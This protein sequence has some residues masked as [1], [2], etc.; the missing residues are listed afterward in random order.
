MD[1]PSDSPNGEPPPF[2]QGRL[3]I[4]EAVSLIYP[5]IQGGLNL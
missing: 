4:G 3:F 2:T 5:L 1:N